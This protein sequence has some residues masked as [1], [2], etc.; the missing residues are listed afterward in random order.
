MKHKWD[1]ETKKKKK[2]C[3][4]L[5]RNTKS[6]VKIRKRFKQ[7]ARTYVKLDKIRIYSGVSLLMKS[8]LFSWCVFNRSFLHPSARALTRRLGSRPPI[9]W[10]IRCLVKKKK[11]QTYNGVFKT[12]RDPVILLNFNFATPARVLFSDVYCTRDIKYNTTS[13]PR[14]LPRARDT[15]LIIMFSGYYI[16][17]RLCVCVYSHTTREVVRENPFHRDVAR[18]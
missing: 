3:I 4:S 7:N 17:V 5:Q 1:G 16:V 8:L 12:V 15:V 9:V 10:R 6:N 11:A 18:R 14:P 13:P 2:N